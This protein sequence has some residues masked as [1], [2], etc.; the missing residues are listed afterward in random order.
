LEKVTQIKI[1][2][3]QASVNPPF[4]WESPVFDSYAGNGKTPSVV[5]G[6]A[7]FS[8]TDPSARSATFE[9]TYGDLSD[10]TW[11]V[12]NNGLYRFLKY[13]DSVP[14]Y[15]V[16]LGNFYSGFAASNMDLLSQIEEYLFQSDYT[17]SNALLT[18][19]ITATNNVEANTLEFYTLYSNYLHAVANNGEFTSSDSLD[20]RNLIVL[21]PEESGNCIYQARALY[22]YIFSTIPLYPGCNSGTGAKSGEFAT[23]IEE[24]PFTKSE[25]NIFP[26][27]NN[28]S[29]TNARKGLAQIELVMVYDCRG[30]LIFQKKLII[31]HSGTAIDLDI[32][33]GLYQIVISNNNG[34]TETKKILISK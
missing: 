13:N 5:A 32:P 10:D 19:G 1:N 28:G 33:S 23:T 26:N 8:C 34:L 18:S 22:E 3:P 30:K 17:N 6:G 29:F 2:P 9:S 7:E 12:I 27:P 21:C 14:A 15:N 25:F 16:D 24:I 31:T 11:S 4:N 20:L